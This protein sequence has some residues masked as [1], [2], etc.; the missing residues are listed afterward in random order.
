MK[1][2]IEEIWDNYQVE[3]SESLTGEKRKKHLNMS[4]QADKLLEAL[5]PMQK[6]LFEKYRE[7]LAI[8]QSESDKACFADGVK[9]GIRLILDSIKEAP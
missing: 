4:K 8:F 3:I 7:S 9:F 2:I 5:N 1:N 6:E